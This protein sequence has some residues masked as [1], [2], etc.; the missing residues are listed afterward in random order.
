MQRTWNRIKFRSIATSLHLLDR[1]PQSKANSF[2][3]V[4]SQ[5]PQNR[6]GTYLNCNLMKPCSN[7]CQI[8]VYH[9]FK[10]PVHVNSWYNLQT[11]HYSKLTHTADPLQISVNA[12][13]CNNVLYWRKNQLIS[14]FG[15][16]TPNVSKYGIKKKR[17]ALN[18]QARISLRNKSPGAKHTVYWLLVCV[19][20]ACPVVLKLQKEL[21]GKLYTVNRNKTISERTEYEAILTL[22]TVMCI[23]CMPV[24]V[25][26][27]RSACLRQFYTAT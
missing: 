19:F 1:V 6:K 4:Q 12:T 11:L 23:G 27:L 21:S 3:I 14:L 8:W 17:Y 20:K 22:L 24:T 26:S 7:L 18:I 10:F 2:K 13:H 15:I 5:P 9:E 16:T 25:S